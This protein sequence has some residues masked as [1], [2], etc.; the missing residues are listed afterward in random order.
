[1]KK[2]IKFNKIIFVFAAIGILFIVSFAATNKSLAEILVPNETFTAHNQTSNPPT[3]K[4][5]S[6]YAN[7]V[8][9]FAIVLGGILAVVVITVGGFEY[10]MAGGNTSTVE[11]AKNRIWQAI[12]GLLVIIG[13]WLILSTINPDLV[14]LNLGI[15]PL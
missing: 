14:N 15:T 11:K 10:I 4:P 8:L 2:N 5:F 1:M 9:K 13:A 7:D 6:S 3:V 12:L